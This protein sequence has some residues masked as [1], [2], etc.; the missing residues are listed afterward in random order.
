[1]GLSSISQ[2]WRIFNWKKPLNMKDPN[3]HN[4]LICSIKHCLRLTY[5][6]SLYF[7]LIQHVMNHIFVYLHNGLKKRTFT[8][9]ANA[10]SLSYLPLLRQCL[11]YALMIT[12]SQLKLLIDALFYVLPIGRSKRGPMSSHELFDYNSSKTLCEDTTILTEGTLRILSRKL[13]RKCRK[14]AL[15]Q[16]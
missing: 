16:K 5:S 12:S 15:Q 6:F 14:L 7:I 8:E 10:S 11:M 2:H 4:W 3:S 1:M 13:S 9:Q